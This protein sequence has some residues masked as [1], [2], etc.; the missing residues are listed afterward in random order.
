MTNDDVRVLLENFFAAWATR[1]T[2]EIGALLSDECTL[3]PPRSISSPITDRN[4]ILAVLSGVPA[5]KFLKVETIDRKI[6][7]M[8]VDDGEAAVTLTLTAELNA[9]GPYENSYCWRFSCADGAIS[10]LTEFTD[11]NHA[12][13]TFS[14]KTS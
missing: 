12:I 11:T 4:T 3:T 2:Q 14:G 6:D 8:L 7:H 13:R 5:A 1:D 9:G 10:A